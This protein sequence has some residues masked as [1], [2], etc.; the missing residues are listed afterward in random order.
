MLGEQAWEGQLA[1][2]FCFLAAGCSVD[3]KAIKRWNVDLAALKKLGEAYRMGWLHNVMSRITPL[4]MRR[5]EDYLAMA[6][7]FI[8]DAAAAELLLDRFE[9]DMELFCSM[10]GIRITNH[11]TMQNIS[12]ELQAHVALYKD[13]NDILTGKFNIVERDP[14]AILAEG[15]F[16]NEATNPFVREFLDSHFETESGK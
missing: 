2:R 15:P 11:M 7:I 13:I 10:A 8:E 14:I 3:Q 1:G 9:A 6:D 12:P 5:R 16:A 4:T